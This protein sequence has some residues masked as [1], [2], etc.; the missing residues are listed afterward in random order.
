MKCRSCG[1]SNPSGVKFCVECGNEIIAY[2]E[3]SSSNSF[4]S[5]TKNNA[6][7]EKDRFGEL[8]LY[9]VVNWLLVALFFTVVL[10]Q[11]LG[12]F[13]DVPAVLGMS[14]ENCY[15]FAGLFL[16]GIIAYSYVYSFFRSLSSFPKDAFYLFGFLNI[17]YFTAIFGLAFYYNNYVEILSYEASFIVGF[18]V[19][20]I[21][22][23]VVNA[24]FKDHFK[25]ISLIGSIKFI[26][27]LPLLPVWIIQTIVWDFKTYFRFLKGNG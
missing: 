4:S 5:T 26:G 6:E 17:P 22:F 14:S 15:G 7:L 12:D 2:E 16:S 11:L 9:R 27:R 20:L 19:G 18:V 10:F 24:T 13:L 3:S 8:A 21:V 1:N 23:F 25:E